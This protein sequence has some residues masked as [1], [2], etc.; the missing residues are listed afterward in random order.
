MF[1]PSS[2]VRGRDVCKPDQLDCAD[3]VV[4]GD[5][6][7]NSVAS[8]DVEHDIGPV[9]ST[10]GIHRFIGVISVAILLLALLLWL[11]F[12]AWR[13]HKIRI[14]LH[15]RS[16]SST[17]GKGEKNSDIVRGAVKNFAAKQSG[18]MVS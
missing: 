7:S 5:G 9:D 8:Q 12:A 3:G 13:R 11:G 18:S 14:L 15:R 10:P 2:H 1:I 4:S 17:I 6:N 16:T